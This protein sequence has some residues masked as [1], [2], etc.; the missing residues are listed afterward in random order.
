MAGL[1]Q[2]DD[3]AIADD[4]GEDVCERLFLS[5]IKVSIEGNGV[6]GQPSRQGALPSRRQGERAQAC[7]QKPEGCFAPRKNDLSSRPSSPLL[8]RGARANNRE[9]KSYA[10]APDL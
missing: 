9:I 6:W 10:T 5:G 2:H 7:R 3:V 8:G 1:P 4:A